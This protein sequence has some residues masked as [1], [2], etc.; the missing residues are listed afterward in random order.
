MGIYLG[1]NKNLQGLV[2]TWSE[3]ERKIT[4]EAPD[5]GPQPGMQKKAVDGWIGLKTGISLRRAN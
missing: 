1:R 4:S 3:G 5:A 2:T